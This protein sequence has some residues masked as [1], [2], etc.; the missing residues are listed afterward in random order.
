MT[1]PNN[2]FL[3]NRTDKERK[4]DSEVETIT[5][6]SNDNFEEE[7]KIE[8]GKWN[9][10]KH[11]GACFECCDFEKMTDDIIDWWIKILRQQK[12]LLMEQGE[13]EII[14]YKDALIWC[15][16]SEDFQLEGKARKGWEKICI[17]LLSTPAEPKC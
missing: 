10:D 13:E 12:V 16:G 6:I 3:D 9:N 4:E 7:C 14:K 1:Q 5:T 2:N 15:S 8:F 11:Y 17:P